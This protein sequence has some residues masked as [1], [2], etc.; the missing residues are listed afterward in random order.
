MTSQAASYTITRDMTLPPLAAE[1]RSWDC[2]WEECR[3]VGWERRSA[4]QPGRVIPMIGL[5]GRIE[6]EG[7]VEAWQ[8]LLRLAPITHIGSHTTFG[9]GAVSVN[10]L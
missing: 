6:I 5:L 1:L 2:R 10:H 7:R 4:A 8:S 3:V 9:M